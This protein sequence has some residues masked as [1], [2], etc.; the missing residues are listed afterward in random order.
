MTDPTTLKLVGRR[1]VVALPPLLRTAARSADHGED[2]FLPAGY[3]EPVA[4]FDVGPNARGT[5][6]AVAQKHEAKDDEVL[7][8]VHAS[9]KRPPC[10]TKGGR[11]AGNC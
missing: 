2:A 5:D 7:V 8:Q 1:A 3:L 11:T 4:A 10:S 9:A 6:A